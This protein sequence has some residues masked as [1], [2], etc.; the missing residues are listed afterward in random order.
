[1]IPSFVATVLRH[2][3]RQPNI[4]GDCPSFGTRT[5]HPSHD[6]TSKIATVHESPDP[7][8][9][10]THVLLPLPIV[11]ESRV[12]PRSCSRSPVCHVEFQPL[13]QVSAMRMLLLCLPSLSAIPNPRGPRFTIA[14]LSS[15]RSTSRIHTPPPTTS[16]NKAHLSTIFYSDP[17][18]SI[19]LG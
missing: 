16:R 17:S 9:H 5:S 18:H 19:P 6:R 14:T 7:L 2:Y 13:L 11:C 10:Q 12:M 3:L 4:G 1:M 8:P 15:A